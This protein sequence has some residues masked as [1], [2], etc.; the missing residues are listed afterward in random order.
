MH[1]LKKFFY[2]FLGLFKYTLEDCQ[3]KILCQ[4]SMQFVAQLNTQRAFNRRKHE[5]FDCMNAPFED[6]QFNFCKI[7]N[8][9]K[10]FVLHPGKNTTL[11][12]YFKD[13]SLKDHVISINVSPIDDC[14]ILLIPELT[15]G[16]FQKLTLT[17]LLLAFDLIQLSNHPGKV[18]KI[19]R[20]YCFFHLIHNIANDI[21][22]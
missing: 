17:S 14:H 1:S 2:M 8:E 7:K 13:F 21:K 12:I 9:E 10:L 18:L 22:N 20:V 5:L 3:Y 11:G 15:K 4:N 6:G 19:F 16:L